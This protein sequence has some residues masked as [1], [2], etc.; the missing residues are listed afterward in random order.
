MQTKQSFYAAREKLMHANNIAI[1]GHAFPDWDSIWSCL[2]LGSALEDSGKDIKYF[3]PTL[4]EE[5]FWFLGA[6]EKFHTEWFDPSAYDCIVLLDTSNQQRSMFNWYDMNEYADRI[7]I[8]DHHTDNSLEGAHKIIY[9]TL[10]STCEIVYKVLNEVQPDLINKTVATFLLLGILTDTGNYLY[11]CNIR[12][13]LST[14]CAL[15]DHWA[16]KER[17]TDNLFRSQSFESVQYAWKLIQ[18]SQYNESKLIL[19]TRYSHQE[20]E[21]VSIDPKSIERWFSMIQSIKHDWIYILFKVIEGHNLLKVSLRTQ[22][23]TINLST[24][25]R[26]LW[27]GWHKKASGISLPLEDDYQR[28]MIT[29]L[30]I[31][32]SNINHATIS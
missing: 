30:E 8:I 28:Q 10:S 27:W 11:W 24:L 1:C 21:K 12:H 2:W 31:L 13:A 6:T 9:T 26:V 22:Q 4:P 15:I 20:L 23:D 32:E 17:L 5:Y 16:P 19:W 18:R 29:I 3:S 14:S 25:A 7:I